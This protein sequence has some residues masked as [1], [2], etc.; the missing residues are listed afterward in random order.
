MWCLGDCNFRTWVSSVL[1]LGCWAMHYTRSTVRVF[2]LFDFFLSGR[3][4]S[5]DQHIFKIRPWISIVTHWQNILDHILHSF[6][7]NNHTEVANLQWSSHVQLGGPSDHI[8]PQNIEWGAGNLVA[9]LLCGKSLNEI[10]F[11][12]RVDKKSSFS[13]ALA[14]GNFLCQPFQ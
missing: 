10:S 11:T 12:L 7:Q 8:A 5:S 6:V 9:P 2:V 4:L 1:G 3:N 14:L 13:K